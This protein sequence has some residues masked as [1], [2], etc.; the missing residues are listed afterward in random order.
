[1]KHWHFL[2]EPSPMVTMV[3]TLT[4]AIICIFQEIIQLLFSYEFVLNVDPLICFVAF[5]N[6]WC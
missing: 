1:M 4:K 5:A 2:G 6:V 3:P